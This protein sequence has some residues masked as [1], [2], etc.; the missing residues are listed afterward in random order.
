[1]L[2]WDLRVKG[3]SGIQVRSPPGQL[4][5]IPGLGTVQLGLP[6]AL[7]H[8]RREGSWGP[9]LAGGWKEGS[10]PLSLHLQPAMPSSFPGLE[11][12]V[13]GLADLVVVGGRPKAEGKVFGKLIPA[14]WPLGMARE[15]TRLP[16]G[17]T[18]LLTLDDL[19]WPVRI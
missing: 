12:K 2:P 15:E 4:V 10:S 6:G 14:F 7:P 11:L 13:L 9:G 5:L 1:M 8:L 17:H 16:V 18:T 3:A 19:R